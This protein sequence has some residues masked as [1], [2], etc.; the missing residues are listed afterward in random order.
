V[1]VSGWMNREQHLIDYLREENRIL[2]EKLGRK[3]I[4][5]N[6]SQKQCLAA[7]AMKLGKDLLRLPCSYGFASGLVPST[8]ARPSHWARLIVSSSPRPG[9]PGISPCWPSQGS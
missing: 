7:A 1:A 4:I 9:R 2:R 6:E 5:L 3:R 8:N